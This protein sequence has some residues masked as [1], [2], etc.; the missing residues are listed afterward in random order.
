MWGKNPFYIIGGI[1]NADIAEKEWEGWICRYYIAPT[2]PKA[3]VK[4]LVGRKNVEIYMMDEDVSWNGMFWRF[5]PASDP[6][7]DV[8]ISRD[9][10]SRLSVRDKAAVDEWLNSDKDFHI[11]RDCCQHGWP[12]CGG[13]WGCRN[14]VISEMVDLIDEYPRKQHDNNHGIDQKFLGS[15][16]YPRVIQKTYVHDDWFPHMYRN[17]IKHQFPIPRL[18]GQNWWKTKFPEWHSGIENSKE[19]YPH[20]FGEGG[21]GHCYLQCPACGVYHD[22]D[23]IGKLRTVTEQEKQTYIHVLN[24]CS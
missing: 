14:G 7:V 3:A 1:L 21:A 5:Y 12:I 2:V 8:M 11:L 10:D 19:K 18:R 17:E 6:S 15:E 13:A 23:Y 4:E 9:T 22:N 16:I 24:E 20:W